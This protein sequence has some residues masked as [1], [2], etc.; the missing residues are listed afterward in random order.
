[1][2]LGV[3]RYVRTD[4]HL[5]TKIFE[6]AGLSNFLTYGAPLTHPRYTGAPLNI[7][8]FVF[9]KFKVNE[10]HITIRK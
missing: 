10:L 5:T 3:L 8:Y 4:S 9:V 2:G 7:I 1:M 6:I